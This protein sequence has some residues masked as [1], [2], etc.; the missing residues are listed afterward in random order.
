MQIRASCPPVD[1]FN[2]VY[3]VFFLH[4]IGTLLPWNMFITANEYFLWQLTPS[5]SSSAAAAVNVS[6]VPSSSDYQEDFLSFV[7][8]ASKLPNTGVQLLMVLSMSRSSAKAFV[9]RTLISIMVQSL[10]FALTIV[11]AIVSSSI[12]ISLFY[13]LT[14][15]TIVLMNISNGVHQSCMNGQAVR[16]EERRYLNAVVT[17][18][19][20]SGIVSSLFMITSLALTPDLRSSAIVYFS[21]AIAMLMI[22]FASYCFICRTEFFRHCLKDDPVDDVDGDN[23]KARSILKIACRV[24]HQLLNVFLVYAS[25]FCLFPSVLADVRSVSSFGGK[26]FSVTFCFLSFNLFAVMGN[27][28]AGYFVIHKNRLWILVIARLAFIPYF[29][30]CNYQVME[31]TSAV[32]L[33]HDAFF[34]VGVA[35]FALSFGYTSSLCIIAAGKSVQSD[36]ASTAAMLASVVL[37]SGIVAG[38]ALSFAWSSLV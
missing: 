36:P 23:T 5:S 31:R 21:T 30:L 29:L 26:F 33:S 32:L 12:S 28:S 3:I 6:S 7:G 27:V 14:M 20:V 4:G 11:L 18:M 19:N 24:W 15:I 35:L 8:L 37:M 10:L 34:M 22:C 9:P 17:G 16:M 13:I 25:T 1:H 2:I 38:F